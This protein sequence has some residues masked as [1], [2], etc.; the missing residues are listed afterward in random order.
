[1]KKN[2]LFLSTLCLLLS[3]FTL[4]RAQTPN[5][6]PPI[7]LIE[8]EDIKPGKMPT[9]TQEARAYV[10]VMQKA[11]ARVS[12]GMQDGR[13][14]MTPV[15]GNQNEV[16]YVWPYMSF[17]DMASKRK[18]NDKMATG[19]M[20]ADFDNLPDAE[21]HASQR[22]IIA[23]YRPEHSYNADK[24]DIRQARYMAVTTTRIKPGHGDEYWRGVREIVNKARAEAK[25][26]GSFAVYQVRAGMTDGIYLSFRLMKSMDELD[27]PLTKV[28]DAMGKEGREDMDKIADRSVMFSETS[29]YAINPGLSIVS[30]DFVAADPAFW[31][32]KPP[33]P[34]TTTTTTRRKQTARRNGM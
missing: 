3:G 33:A 32:Q 16:M 10:E 13:I 1:M 5:A 25:F 17:A 31:N 18:E 8:R 22:T 20:R 6:P 14:A 7:L 19:V 9:H 27:F 30:P 26:P 11:N 23:S 12:N 4:T 15:A 24:Q 29:Y 28:R 21:L 34:A 2:F